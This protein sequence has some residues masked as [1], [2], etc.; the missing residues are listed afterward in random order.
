MTAASPDAP[1]ANTT[2]SRKPY[3]SLAVLLAAG[4]GCVTVGWAFQPEPP[5]PGATAEAPSEQEIKEKKLEV[6][7]FGGGCFWC[8]E[9]PF[10][11]LE[12][13]ISTTSGYTAGNV[14][15]PTYYQ[16]S[17]G[18]T[19]HTEAMKIVFDPEKIDYETLLGMFWRNIDPFQVNGQFV[20][21]GTQYRTAICYTTPEQKKIAEK[22]LKEVEKRFDR[23]VATELLPASEFYDAEDY[24]QNFYVKSPVRYNSYRAACGRDPRLKELWGDEAGGKKILEKHSK[25]AAS[26]E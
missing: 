5:P 13:V 23:T 26:E 4:F 9:K 18:F 15:D 22:T 10:D 16:V 8:L 21:K 12:G 3:A 11:K 20:D 14:K 7:I 17:A 25:K 24:H 1:A 2:G 19:G 6:A